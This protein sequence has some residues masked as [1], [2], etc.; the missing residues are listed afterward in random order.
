MYKISIFILLILNSTFLFAN[1][2]KLEKARQKYNSY[3]SVS[4][5]VAAHYPNPETDEMTI[6]STFYI[7]NNFKNKN[8]EYYSKKN[9]SEEFYKNGDY[10]YVNNDEKSIYKYEEKKNQINN[11]HNST[12][13]QY[14]PTFLLNNKWKCE[15]EVLVNK[16]KQSRYS[17]IEDVHEYEGKTIKVIFEIYISS[18]F[19]ISKLE[20]K[21]Y[22]DNKIGQIVSFEYT[23]YNF[24][25]KEIKFKSTLPQNYALKYYERTEINPLQKGATAPSFQL[26]DISGKEFSSIDFFGHRT[27]LLFSSTSCG[28]S[29]E[30][31]D[32]ISGENF[33]LPNDLKL[34][35]AYASDKK[36][37]VLKYLKN[38]SKDFTIFSD[39]KEIQT[40]YQIAGYPVLYLINGNGVIEETYDGYVQIIQFLKSLNQK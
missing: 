18:N 3:N 7:L 14:G 39:V 10:S 36:E 6:F 37:N 13:V 9:N 11:F 20:R 33:I 22:V 1:N 38:K 31:S 26:K 23:N 2:I 35:D 24:S 16:K 25:K 30:V 28:A 12:L 34:I 29:K 21:S 8:F 17:F 5:L 27:L 19:T 32:Y 40:K 4:Y 15:D